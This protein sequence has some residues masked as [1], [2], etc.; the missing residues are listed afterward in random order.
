VWLQLSLSQNKHAGGKGDVMAYV[1]AYACTG[2]SKEG[3]IASLGQEGTTKT[4]ER[5]LLGRKLLVSQLVTNSH[6]YSRHVSS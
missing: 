3:H 4:A 1:M 2:L 6:I 5:L